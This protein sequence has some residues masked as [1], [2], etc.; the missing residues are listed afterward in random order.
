[1]KLLTAPTL[2]MLS[3][4]VTVVACGEDE[5]EPDSM[6]AAGSGGQSGQV[7][8]GTGGTVDPHQIPDSGEPGVIMCAEI[9]TYCHAYDEGT[10]LGAE[11]HETGHQGDPEA[12]AAIYDECI[13]FCRSDAGS[14]ANDE[15]GGDAGEGHSHCEELGHLCHDLDDGGSNLAHECHETGHAGDEAAC[16]AIFD[17]CVA[18]CSPA[19]AGD[20]AAPACETNGHG[21]HTHP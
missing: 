3:T 10:G 11:C 9:G 17:Q 4:L 8:G 18:L 5:S 7:E 2:L 12:C 14:G 15:D 19:D 1:M 20:G 16:E 6:S 21:C 13:A